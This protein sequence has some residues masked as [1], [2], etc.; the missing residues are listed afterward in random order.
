M[1]D[2][3]V[4]RQAAAD[5]VEQ[6]V[7]IAVHQDQDVIDIAEILD[8]T[9]FFGLCIELR[10]IDYLLQDSQTARQTRMAEKN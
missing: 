8:L 9:K 5:S 4:V 1:G 6:L 7:Q 10:Q 2:Y 3:L